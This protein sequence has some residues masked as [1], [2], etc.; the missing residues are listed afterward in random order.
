M[1]QLQFQTMSQVLLRK[2]KKKLPA[3]YASAIAAKSSQLSLRRIRGVF[4]G[5]VTDPKKVKEVILVAKLVIAENQ[6]ITS[7]LTPKT[8]SI[9]SK[10]VK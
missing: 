4:N 7:L 2:L 1:T 3:K 6:E 10:K 5:E 9:K 8:M